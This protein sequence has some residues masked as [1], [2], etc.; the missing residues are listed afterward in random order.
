MAS[1]YEE[2]IFKCPF[3]KFMFEFVYCCTFKLS[4]QG[5]TLP[6]LKLCG[7]SDLQ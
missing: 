7:T 4:A 2:R 6:W 1:Y 3:F 5:V